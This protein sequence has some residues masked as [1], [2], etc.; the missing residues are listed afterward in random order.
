MLMLDLGQEKRLVGKSFFSCNADAIALFFPLTENKFGEHMTSSVKKPLY[1]VRG[2]QLDH[3]KT[4]FRVYAPHAKSVSLLLTSNKTEQQFQM[5]KDHEGVWK[6]SCHA[7][8]KHTY[9]F[10][11]EGADGKKMLRTDPFSFETKY[12]ETSK[13]VESVVVDPKA[14]RW[15]DKKWLEERARHDPLT[16][17]L[18]IYEVQGKSWKTSCESPQ[19]YK[20]LAKDLAAYC[21]KMNFTHV[22][23]YGLLDHLNPVEDGYQIA[24]F[25]APY[26]PQGSADDVKALVDELHKTGIGVIIDWVGSHYFAQCQ[27]DDY[28]T[29]LYNFDGTDL[30]GS[31]YTPWGTLFFDYNKEETKHLMQASALYWLAE[32]HLDGIRFD[33]VNSMIHRDDKVHDEAVT[34]LKELNAAVRKEFPGVLLIAEESHDYPGLTSE[35]SSGGLGFDYKWAISWSDETRDF[36]HQSPDKRSSEKLSTIDPFL[37]SVQHDAK[38]LLTHSHDDCDI[39]HGPSNNSLY[40]YVYSDNDN[41][42]VR[43]ATLRNFFSWQAFGPSRGYLMH[44]GDEFGQK[45]SWYTRFQQKISSVDWSEAKSHTHQKLQKCVKDLNAL[46]QKKQHLFKHG[47]QDYKLISQDSAILAYTRKKLTVIHNF[48]D[49]AYS[50][51]EVSTKGIE[52]KKFTEIFNSDN[53]TY[54]GSG[55]F[56]NRHI[57]VLGS[58]IRVKL[59]P[60]STHIFEGE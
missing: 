12:I 56:D 19:N 18:C 57:Q 37:D 43:F 55:N 54:G 41:D 60:N 47:E 26:R 21:K 59:A 5:V 36:L 9:L 45:R 6:T 10:A 48:S 38:Q 40:E 1:K 27:A 42:A 11:V 29:T 33:A 51:Y 7:P 4:T 13:R 53:T 17:P 23:L 22:E 24:H 16:K 20:E 25:F 34:F 8:A 2:A 46:Y 35:V 44:M 52:A 49:K 15:G 14:Y 31:E 3:D 32:M 39:S 58:H 50:S 28:C 30:F